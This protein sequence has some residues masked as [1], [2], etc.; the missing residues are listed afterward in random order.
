M[1]VKHSALEWKILVIL[2]FYF[3]EKSGSRRGQGARPLE[4]FPELK[5]TLG[6]S[7]AAN[8]SSFQPR[9]PIKNYPGAFRNY[10]VCGPRSFK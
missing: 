10:S 6:D 2:R 1:K 8:H 3:S 4:G 7:G 9:H 5:Q